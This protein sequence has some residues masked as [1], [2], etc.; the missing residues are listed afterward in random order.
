M[1]KPA[2]YGAGGSGAGGGTGGLSGFTTLRVEGRET[3]FKGG[4]PSEHERLLLRRATS[5][6]VLGQFAEAVA[7]YRSAA[8]LNPLGSQLAQEGLR[9]AWH[10]AKAALSAGHAHLDRLTRWRT[11]GGATGGQ[12]G[13]N[14]S[15]PSFQSSGKR[16]STP[17]VDD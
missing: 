15:R 6:A 13:T 16:A 10:D 7:D 17:P 5:F 1:Y 14:P 4:A 11:T 3:G 9:D 2:V 12:R 8:A